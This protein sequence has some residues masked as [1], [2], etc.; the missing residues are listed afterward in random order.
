MKWIWYLA[1][2]SLF[3]VDE[4][5]TYLLLRGIHT[6]FSGGVQMFVM[7]G[8]GTVVVLQVSQYSFWLNFHTFNVVLMVHT[9]E[10]M[11][12]FLCYNIMVTVKFQLDVTIISCFNKA[13]HQYT[14]VHLQIRTT[15]IL[16]LR[17]WESRKGRRL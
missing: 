14:P 7:C 16:S 5:Y 11:L 13:S 17:K 15:N 4:Y 10:Y 6:Q 12:W 8:I 1:L 2:L 9:Y 3:H